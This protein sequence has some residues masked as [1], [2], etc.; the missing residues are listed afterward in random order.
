[1]PARRMPADHPTPD[2]QSTLCTRVVV[3]LSL[4]WGLSCS[5][6]P[7][8]EDETSGSAAS[9]AGEALHV[10]GFGDVHQRELDDISWARL[11]SAVSEL[12]SASDRGPND[13]RFDPLTNAALHLHAYGY[14]DAA[15]EMYR[16]M[17]ERAP[18]ALAAYHRAQIAHSRGE[19]ESAVSGM[20]NAVRLSPADPALQVWLAEFEFAAGDP[21][22]AASTA[23]RLI[24]LEPRL[25][26]AHAQLGLALLELGKPDEARKSLEEALRLDPRATTLFHTLASAHRQLGDMEAA[27]DAIARAGRGLP[28]VPDAL[29]QQLVSLRTGA[30]SLMVTG[31]RAMRAGHIGQAIDAFARAVELSPDNPS[32]NLNLGAAL[33]QAGRSEEAVRQM[34]RVLELD[35]TPASRSMAHFNLA[36]L[37]AANGEGRD[38]A[39]DHLRASIEWNPENQAA[40]RLL[41]RLRANS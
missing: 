30:S 16:R 24:V 25:G 2:R 21:T 6:S 31:G 7:A 1:M 27:R 36:A 8:P 10:A 22:A 28:S 17:Q 34:R 12:D 3:A 5:P 38:E 32:A 39:L 35:L 11:R 19:H 14:L 40:L 13:A 15:L 20:R 26:A 18:S 9:R 33:A 4:A 41:E 37:L 23:Q 29:H